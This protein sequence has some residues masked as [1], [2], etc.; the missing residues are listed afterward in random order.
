[1]DHL[2]ES[3]SRS[4]F[5][6]LKTFKISGKNKKTDDGLCKLADVVESLTAYEKDVTEENIVQTL[7]EK[8]HK[9]V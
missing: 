2:T 4:K 6:H 7:E 3:V 1:M 8:L 9:Y 5:N